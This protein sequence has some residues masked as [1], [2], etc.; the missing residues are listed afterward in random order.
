MAGV[1]FGAFFGEVMAAEGHDGLDFLGHFPLFFVGPGMVV[2]FVFLAVEGE[3]VLGEFEFFEVEGAF[4]S[5][6]GFAFFVDLEAGVFAELGEL[7]ALGVA[8][9]FGEAFFFFPIFVG[10]D[11]VEAGEEG[12]AGLGIGGQGEGAFLD[13]D[14]A[15][16]GDVGFAGGEEVVELVDSGGGVVDEVEGFGEEEFMFIAVKGGLVETEMEFG[17]D[18]LLGVGE[19]FVA[20]D[21]VKVF[22]LVAGEGGEFGEGL[23]GAG[24]FSAIC[25]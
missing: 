12:G 23:E 17:P 19:G 24:A 3:A 4:V 5:V 7:E 21:F 16:G 6:H 15:G 25:F 10:E 20:D 14:L 11:A 9:F 2:L 1:F 22:E 8:A 13:D 18:F